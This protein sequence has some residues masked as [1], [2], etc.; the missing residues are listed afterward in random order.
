MQNLEV[1]ST[2]EENGL[3]IVNGAI[4]GNKGSYVFVYDAVKRTRPAKAPFPAGLKGGS[5]KEESAPAESEQA[6]NDTQQGN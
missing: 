5:K 1:I 4:P 6:A 3:I 2:D